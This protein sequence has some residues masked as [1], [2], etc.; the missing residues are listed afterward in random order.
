MDP[1]KRC[2]RGRYLLSP[3]SQTLPASAPGLLAPQHSIQ[4]WEW[5]QGLGLHHRDCITGLLSPASARSPHFC[6]EQSCSVALHV[7]VYAKLQRFVLNSAGA[8][9]S[10]NVCQQGTREAIQHTE[11][12]RWRNP[13]RALLSARMGRGLPIQA[14][15]AKISFHSIKLCLQSSLGLSLVAVHSALCSG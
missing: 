9:N 5:T 11:G 2:P 12:S 13:A 10:A 15:N 8:K 14:I 1:Q 4:E 3:R 7:S 6:P